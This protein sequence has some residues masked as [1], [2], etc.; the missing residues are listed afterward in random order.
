MK[1]LKKVLV[2]LMVI[3]ITFSYYALMFSVHAIDIYE[4]KTEKIKQIESDKYTK[5]Y[6]EYMELSDEEKEKY[7]VVPPKYNVPIDKFTVENENK[8]FNKSFEEVNIYPS[9]IKKL[10]ATAT[11]TGS[12]LP[13]SYDLRKANPY[14]LQGH[15]NITIDKV[16][17]QGNDGLCWIYATLGALK[18][19]LAVKG[20]TSSDGKTLDFSEEHMNYLTS[21]LYPSKQFADTNSERYRTISGVEGGTVEYAEIY[22]ANNDGPI[23]ESK[24]NVQGEPTSTDL[25]NLDNMVPDYYIHEITQFPSIVKQKVHDSQTGKDTVQYLNSSQQLDENTVTNIRNNIK[26][27][28]TENGGLYCNIRIKNDVFRN[29]ETSSMYDDGTLTF[30]QCD[31]AHALTIIG[32][33]DEYPKENF[34]SDPN[35]QPTSNGAYLALNSWGP[36]RFPYVWISYEDAYIESGLSG[37]KTVDKT[38]KNIEYKFT[39][40]AI[41]EKMVSEL[42]KYS[43]AIKTDDNNK[44]ISQIPD[45]TTNIINCIN[46]R[47]LGKLSNKPEML[48]EIFSYIGTYPNLYDMETDDIEE[49]RAMF[50]YD[51]LLGDLNENNRLDIGDI[52]LILKYVE[53]EKNSNSNSEWYLNIRKQIMAD[54]NRDQKIDLMD[55]LKLEQ[56]IAANNDEN[57]ANNKQNWKETEIIKLFQL[58]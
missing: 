8:E 5:E 26:K 15:G 45:V 50:L 41:Y 32:W 21:S 30:E 28:I 31:S 27:H 11:E 14:N 42:K 25:Q 22:F 3:I 49:G 56:N 46:L 47:G 9:F 54:T 2:I 23:L 48:K 6:Q 16:E 37:F 40:E 19:H 17:D 33:N 38:P 18:T 36:N 44:T 57:V 52:I 51:T 10:L 4:D 35:K 29:D 58:Q 53:Y 34:N 7:D 1:N 39:N 55:I 20:E 13:K 43:I 12:T 24:C